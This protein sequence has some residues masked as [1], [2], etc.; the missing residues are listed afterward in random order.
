MQTRPVPNIREALIRFSYAALAIAVGA[1]T[2][3]AAVA[4]ASLIGALYG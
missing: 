1:A 2:A 3:A 4:V